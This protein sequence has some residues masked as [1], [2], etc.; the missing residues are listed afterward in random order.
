MVE[1]NSVLYGPAGRPALVSVLPEFPCMTLSESFRLRSCRK[2]ESR[3]SRQPGAVST[4]LVA[5]W[6]TSKRR[7]FHALGYL[8]LG[9]NAAEL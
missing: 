8:G 5:V 6:P 9:R 7:Q 4:A 3:S 1:G 2:E